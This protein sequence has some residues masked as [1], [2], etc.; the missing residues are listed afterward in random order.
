MSMAIGVSVPTVVGAPVDVAV[1]AKAAEELGF[2]SIWVPEH[3]VL[4]VHTSS[5]W[6]GS[7]DG[8]IPES[9]SHMID[10]F[11]AL[12]RASA[13]TSTLKLGTG[14]CLVPERNPML[15]AKVIAT[16]DHFSGGRFLFGI[17]AGWLREETE[18]MGGNF[19]HRWGHTRE[20]VLAMKELWTKDEAEYHGKYVDFPPV[21]SYPK[22]AQKPHPPVILGGMAKNVLRRVVAWGDGWLP[23]RVTPEQV[24]AGRAQLDELASAAG[25]D[26]NAIQ[27]SVFGQPPDRELIVGFLT[28]GASRVVVRLN[29]T[30]TED[31]AD[32]LE[33]MARQVLN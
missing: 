4:P 23:N 1:L 27:I 13:V 22:P 7:P 20:S 18:M 33:K 10:P 29:G 16:L 28:A 25:R 5:P 17:G 30:S 15:L 11:V 12:S 31:A 8:V 14:I 2:E 6:P 9:Y 24:K 3:P 19:P 26:P 32:Q 21:R